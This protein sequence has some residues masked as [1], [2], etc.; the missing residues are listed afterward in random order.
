MI[1][2]ICSGPPPDSTKT[3][4]PGFCLD[5]KGRDLRE[6]PGLKPLS[7]KY[8][9]FKDCLKACYDPFGRFFLEATGCE[10]YYYEP[11]QT[12]SIHTAEVV[13]GGGRNAFTCYL[14]KKRGMFSYFVNLFM[15]TLSNS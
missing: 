8:A 9:T 2:L 4:F 13:S 1:T 14:M 10:Y 3:K 12:C 11:K 7:G 5:S 15:L 6:D